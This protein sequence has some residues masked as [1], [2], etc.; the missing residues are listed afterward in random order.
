[1]IMNT[2][3]AAT[4]ALQVSMFL[5]TLSSGVATGTSTALLIILE[6]SLI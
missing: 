1:M 3:Q 6:L 4:D 5:Y 2:Q